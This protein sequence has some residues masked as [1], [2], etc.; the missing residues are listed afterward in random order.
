MVYN[1]IIFFHSHHPL[2]LSPLKGI[3]VSIVRFD[4]DLDVFVLSRQSNSVVKK[5]DLLVH[6]VDL[7]YNYRRGG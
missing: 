2:L 6:T 1:I 5:T 4:V 3:V 7:H